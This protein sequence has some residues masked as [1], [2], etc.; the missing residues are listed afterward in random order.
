[1]ELGLNHISASGHIGFGKYGGPIGSLLRRPQKM[2]LECLVYMY[3]KF[4]ASPLEPGLSHSNPK[5]ET[6]LNLSVL[7]T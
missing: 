6:V 4:H 7:C 1:M 3:A 2:N 5:T